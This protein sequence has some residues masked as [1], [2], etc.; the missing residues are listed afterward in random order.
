[1]WEV[2]GSSLEL[3]L[4]LWPCS[5][6]QRFFVGVVPVHSLTN[7]LSPRRLDVCA[8]LKTFL[9]C[10]LTK[11]V[12]NGRICIPVPQLNAT[13]CVP[14]PYSDWMYADGFERRTEIASWVNVA[15]M[16]STLFILFSYAFL[17]VKWTS[18]HYLSVCLA[19]GV[20]CIEVCITR[21]CLD[22]LTKLCSLPS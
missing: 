18:R 15:A 16:F 10:S 20:L 3:H 5:R 11:P 4:P 12:I 9:C 2:V 6:I 19:L 14:C 22:S 21:Q 1:M 13:C 7:L 17:P 8:R